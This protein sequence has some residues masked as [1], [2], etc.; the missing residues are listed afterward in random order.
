MPGSAAVPRRPAIRTIATRGSR[1]PGDRPR[2]V[3]HRAGFSSSRRR[4][5][6][7]AC[8]N[9]RSAAPARPPKSRGAAC[10]LLDDPGRWRPSPSGISR[11]DRTKFLCFRCISRSTASIVSYVTACELHMLAAACRQTATGLGAP[12]HDSM[13]SPGST[14]FGDAMEPGFRTLASGRS[15][16]GRARPVPPQRSSSSCC[17]LPLPVPLRWRCLL[18]SRLTVLLGGVAP[19]G[20]ARRGVSALWRRPWRTL[21]PLG[22]AAAATACGAGRGAWRDEH[23]VYPRWKPAPRP[24][25]GAIEFLGTVLRPPPGRDPASTP[26]PPSST[27]RVWPPS[28]AIRVHRAAAR[29]RLRLRELRAV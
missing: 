16:L 1:G 27:T 17:L 18:F 9:G 19:G 21:R 13:N 6:A 23:G 25:S 5:S 2:P 15:G 29:V 3:G 4:P 20:P 14:A 24:R 10:S 12:W 8:R 26:R 22:R 28:P 11:P 7:T